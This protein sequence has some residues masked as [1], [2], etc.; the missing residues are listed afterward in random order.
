MEELEGDNERWY[1]RAVVKDH[2]SKQLGKH[3]RTVV[4]SS[5]EKAK[6]RFEYLVE[7]DNMTVRRFIGVAQR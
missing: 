5:E 4:S 2:A 7:S 1:V 3:A 6:R